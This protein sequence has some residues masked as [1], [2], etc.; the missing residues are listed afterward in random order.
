VG[1]EDQFVLNILQ[2][3]QK[4]FALRWRLVH[5]ALLAAFIA[6]SALAAEKGLPVPRFVTLRVDEVNLRTGP[7]ERYPIDWVLTKKGMPVEIIAE[8]DVWR[9]IRDMQGTEGWVH[10]RMVTGSR[11]VIVE[12]EVRTLR[13]DPDPTSTAVA[14]A[15][16]NVIARLLECRGP[17]C[18][19]EL[20]GIKGW[21]R[22][23]EVWGVY[24]DE[25]VQ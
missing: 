22:R 19:V 24:P 1:L 10:Q 16:P 21:L 18:R 5:A 17:W 15:E 7:G 20:R 14:R 11:N 8:F 4:P 25:V 2:T 23:N 13:A 9:Q 6:S 12:G 3:F